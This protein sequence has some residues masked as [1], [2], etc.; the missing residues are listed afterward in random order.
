MVE[1]RND[2]PGGKQFRCK[3]FMLCGFLTLAFKLLVLECNFLGF[4]P[5]RKSK[6]L[7]FFVATDN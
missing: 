7:Y 1:K 5:E 4:V 6:Q 2:R 3:H